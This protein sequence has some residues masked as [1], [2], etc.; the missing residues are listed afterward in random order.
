MAAALKRE[1]LVER[2]HYNPEQEILWNK[3][4]LAQKF[5]TSSLNQYGYKLAFI[6]SGGTGSLAVLLRGQDIATITSDGEINTA[7][8]ILIRFA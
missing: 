3:L 5:A 6:R 7:A 1:T 4:S 8:N 2:R